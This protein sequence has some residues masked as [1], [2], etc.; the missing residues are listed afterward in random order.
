M[1]AARSTQLG[2]GALLAWALLATASSAYANGRFPRAERLIEN[3]TDPNELWLGATYGLVVTRDRGRTWRHVC[4]AG[5][6]LDSQYL[7]DPLISFASNGVLAV[8]VQASLNV[9]PDDGCQWTPALLAGQGNVILDYTVVPSSRSNLVALLSES[10]DGGQITTLE[11][12]TDNGTT[13]NRVGSPLPVLAAYTVDVAPDDP[14]RIYATGL[15]NESGQFLISSDNG[16]TWT[17]HPIPGTSSEGRPFIAGVD[18][19]DRKRIFVRTD[20]WT[21]GANATEVA[22]DSLLY[23]S[24]E[25]QTW[26][27]VFRN[28]AKLFGFAL[29]PDGSTVLLGFGD[30]KGFQQLVTGP[31]G[32]FE[33][34]TNDFAFERIFQGH[35]NCLT[36][37]KTG[38]Y[39]CASQADDQFELAYSPEPALGS[40]AGCL[41]PLLRLNEV[42]GPLDCPTNTAGSACIGDWDTTCG[43]LGACGDAGGSADTRCLPLGTP[44]GDGGDAGAGADAETLDGSVS[45]PVARGLAR[46]ETGGCGCRLGPTNTSCRPL[47]PVFLF[48]ALLLRRGKVASRSRSPKAQRVRFT[49]ATRAR[50]TSSGVAT[51][52][53]KAR[54]AAREPFG[55]TAAISKP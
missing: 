48:L 55:V 31:L 29:S 45:P 18:P 30:P 49:I 54:R 24:D 36:W 40:D 7:G 11:E 25:G 52:A 12:S 37:T 26:K 41:V 28:Q 17:V 53:S 10:V 23:T 42:Q 8:G 39:I 22:N 5:F 35:V 51:V 4:E 44:G 38:V 14:A 15:D 43:V 16:T 6:A 33:S 2:C 50:R 46:A 21:Q 47:V 9:S 1:R 3:P 34:K 27:E 19:A 20:G 32:V 13:W